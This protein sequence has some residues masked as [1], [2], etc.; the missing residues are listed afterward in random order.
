[1]GQDLAHWC[2]EEAE[3][4]MV[5]DLGEARL[6]L[7]L[8]TEALRTIAVIADRGPVTSFERERIAEIAASAI[9]DCEKVI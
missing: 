8:A 3:R 1:V 5:H 2:R 9:A 6:K 7:R 4:A